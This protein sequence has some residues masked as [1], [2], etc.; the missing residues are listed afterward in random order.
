MKTSV[1][2][3]LFKTLL[4]NIAKSVRTAFS[5]EH[6]WWLLLNQEE[7]SKKQKES[8]LHK[9]FATASSGT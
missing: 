2:E 8:S 7:D 6:L 3:C 5:I 9:S 4:K 1:L